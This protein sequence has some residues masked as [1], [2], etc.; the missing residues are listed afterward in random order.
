M[1][2]LEMIGGRNQTDAND[3]TSNTSSMYFPEWIYKDLEKGYNK[4][5]I[6]NGIKS[7]EEDLVRKMKLVGLWCI[8]SSPS[9][10]PPMNRVVEMMEGSTDS[11]DVPPKPVLQHIPAVILP[12]SSWIS[13]EI[14]SPFEMWSWSDG[15]AKRHISF[16]GRRHR[17][18]L[19]L[20]GEN[21]D[22]FNCPDYRLT[23]E[24]SLFTCEG[25][26][27]SSVTY[28]TFQPSD[29]IRDGEHTKVGAVPVL[30]SVYGAHHKTCHKNEIGINWRIKIAM[31]AMLA[32][33]GIV[34]ITLSLWKVKT[35]CQKDQ[36]LEALIPLKQYSYAQVKKITKSFTHDGKGEFGI[37]YSGNLGDGSKVAV[38]DGEERDG[39]EMYMMRKNEMRMNETVQNGTRRKREGINRTGHNEAK[40][41]PDK[42]ERDGKKGMG[43]YETGKNRTRRN[44]EGNRTGRNEMGNRT[45]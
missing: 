34:I 42:A 17:F 1:L 38:K 28:Y 5:I 24:P 37:V 44:G 7:E 23:V 36:N 33:F 2:V 39:K 43:Q 10:S 30:S 45:G 35:F 8:Q 20:T 13:E 29:T 25:S 11:L 16:L 14:L 22:L 9:D 31:G 19:D 21:T 27:K 6:E 4:R 40:I 12:E 3:S 15:V 32:G 18:K 26:N 41:I